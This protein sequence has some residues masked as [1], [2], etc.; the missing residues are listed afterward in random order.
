M[1]PADSTTTPSAPPLEALTRNQALVLDLLRAVGEPLG[2]YAILDHLRDQGLRAPA[3]IYRALERLRT[4]GLVHRLE[5]LN[6]FVACTRG[7]HPSQVTVFVLCD[8][9]GAVCELADDGHAAALAGLAR[10]VGF[11]VFG[12]RIEMHG[13]CGRCDR[14]PLSAPLDGDTPSGA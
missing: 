7:D 2:A 12:G 5:T 11:R 4:L 1:T 3:Q 10:G 8:R 6:A 9:C 13:H 14:G